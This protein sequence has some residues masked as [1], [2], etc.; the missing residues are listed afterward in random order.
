MNKYKISDSFFVNTD[1]KWV[2]IKRDEIKWLRAFEK[3]TVIFLTNNRTIIANHQLSTIAKMLNNDE[4][5][6]Y[7]NRSEIVNV[8]Y[9]DGFKDNCYYIGKNELYVTNTYKT[10]LKEYFEDITIYD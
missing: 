9:I 1:E 3:S 7:I 4:N 6:V 10:Y 5:F 2:R 8:D